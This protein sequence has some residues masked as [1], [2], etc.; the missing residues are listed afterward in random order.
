MMAV[1]EIG[2][3]LSQRLDTGSRALDR[4][5]NQAMSSEGQRTTYV[6]TT[7]HGDIDMMRPF[8]T[9]LNFIIDFWRAL[10]EIGPFL[11][12]FSETMLVGS[13]SSPDNSSRCT[14]RIQTSVGFVSFMSIA[15]VAV[16]RR[17]QFC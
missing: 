1:V 3:G 11:W 14:R 10:T 13:L 16:D 4:D 5:V 17:S 6:F 12:V 2:H 8:E 7:R 15:E 9:A